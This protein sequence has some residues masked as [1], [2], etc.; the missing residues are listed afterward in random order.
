[1]K[2]SRVQANGDL[3]Q[4][5]FAS[6]P[7][8]PLPRRSFKSQKIQPSRLATNE[9]TDETKSQFV[10]RLKSNYCPLSTLWYNSFMFGWIFLNYV[11]DKISAI[12][13]QV[14]QSQTVIHACF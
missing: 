8:K 10:V 7:M 6:Q 5:R 3:V 1:M 14:I 12:V 4:S 11:D 9:V 2:H 13:E